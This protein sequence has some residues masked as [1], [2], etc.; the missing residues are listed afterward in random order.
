MTGL[1]TMEAADRA[2]IG[3]ALQNWGLFRD[4]GDWDALRGL[5]TPD[6]TMQTTWLDGT[7]AEFVDI[8]RRMSAGPA[9]PIH[10]VGVPIVKLAGLRATA[11]TRITILVR[12]PLDGVLVDATCHGWFVDRLVKPAGRW[13]IQSRVPLYERD[14][15]DA[16]DPGASLRID[17]AALA[18]FP[19]CY[20]YMA[21]MQSKV[22]APVNL[23]LPLPGSPEQE[24]LLQ[25]CEAWLA[26]GQT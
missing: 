1:N 25:G 2:A 21:Y 10:V 11:Q 12:A 3:D 16:V 19:A 22:G 17:E 23:N 8:S 15:I 26:S 5:Y 4:R 14:R 20:K 13:L 7:A 6:A 24:R 18:K 9:R